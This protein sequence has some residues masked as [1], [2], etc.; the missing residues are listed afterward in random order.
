MSLFLQFL[1]NYQA[2]NMI[3]LLHLVF[4]STMLR[5]T[6]TSDVNQDL[7]L[8]NNPGLHAFTYYGL[9]ADDISFGKLIVTINTKRVVRAVQKVAETMDQKLKSPSSF[10]K[11]MGRRVMESVNPA[12]QRLKTMD[13]I[14]FQ[15]KLSKRDPMGLAAIAAVSY[16]IYD[17]QQLRGNL[18]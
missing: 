17:I 10:L 15:A 7:T 16:A 8:A 6:T 5:S 11:L 3:H 2:F 4:F 14:L 13:A 18:Q 9:F 12:T 1:M